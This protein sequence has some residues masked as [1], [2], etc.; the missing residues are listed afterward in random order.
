MIDADLQSLKTLIC[1]HEN[2]R[3]RTYRRNESL[4]CIDS[5]VAFP[6]CHEENQ[7]RGGIVESALEDRF[8]EQN[9]VKLKIAATAEGPS[10]R[11]NDRVVDG[12]GRKVIL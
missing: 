7:Q 9:A 6:S 1:A 2:A 11:R 8:G 10:F 12:V 3:T 5:I 4:S